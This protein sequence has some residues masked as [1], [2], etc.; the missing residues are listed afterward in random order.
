MTGGMASPVIFTLRSWKAIEDV[1]LSGNQPRSI[2]PSISRMPMTAH[3][4]HPHTRVTQ[5]QSDGNEA[6]DDETEN[7]LF[8]I[9]CF[10]IECSM[11]RKEED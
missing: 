1:N 4:T 5:I 3:P 7:V 9:E 11:I 8:A 6:E 10:A 2:F